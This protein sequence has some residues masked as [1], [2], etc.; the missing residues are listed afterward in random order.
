MDHGVEPIASPIER[1]AIALRGLR[2]NVGAVVTAL[3]AT[4]V[5]A[6]L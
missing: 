3:V 4:V 6:F 2:I 1:T 5:F